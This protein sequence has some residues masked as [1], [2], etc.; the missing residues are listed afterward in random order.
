MPNLLRSR[1]PSPPRSKTK[2]K[3]TLL[4]LL[5]LYVVQSVSAHMDPPGETQPR[6]FTRDNKFHIL[7]SDSITSNEKGLDMN[8]TYRRVYSPT[9]GLLSQKE[10]IT[11]EEDLS[12]YD[13]PVFF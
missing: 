9:G 7:F 4:F 13:F 8:T 1:H 3:R 11:E 6:V 10:I 5:F 12:Y 2:M